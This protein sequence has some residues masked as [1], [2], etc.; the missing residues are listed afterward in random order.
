MKVID[1]A[2][3]KSV[4]RFWHHHIIAVVHQHNNCAENNHGEVD[5]NYLSRKLAAYSQPGNK[6]SCEYK[7]VH[8]VRVRPEALFGR[9]VCPSW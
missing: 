2:T 9:R 6:A 7:L 4:R 1:L 5:V 3:K 8:E